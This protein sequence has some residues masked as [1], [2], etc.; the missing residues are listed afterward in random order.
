MIRKFNIFY[1][2]AGD[3]GGSGGGGAGGTGSG[4]AGTDAG[5]AGGTQGGAGADG[6]A[7]GTLL[8]GAQSQAGGAHNAG[9]AAGTEA[10]G[11]PKG[12]WGGLVQEDGTFSEA[13]WEKDPEL[14]EHGAHLSK[15]KSVKDALKSNINLQTVL[16]KK[17]DAVIIPGP[18]S[19]KDVVDKFREKLGIPESPDG[20]GLKKPDKLPDGVEWDDA[21]VKEFQK[22]AH[23][24]GITPQQAQKLLQ[25]DL[26]R[27]EKGT[28]ATQ[29]AIIATEKAE[30]KK[31]EEIL[32]KEWG[33][34]A[35]FTKNRELAVRAAI[36][37]G[38]T[39]EQLESDPIFRNASVVKAM[40]KLGSLMSEDTL[41][42]GAENG[43]YNDGHSKA[44]DIISNPQNPYYARY[45]NGDEAVRSMVQEGLRRKK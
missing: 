22:L 4:G 14:K 2:D 9:G 30:L 3:A 10:S 38:F 41:A 12:A 17:A 15:F 26:A 19:P 35:D 1:N 11:A 31:Q 25:F 27:A 23:E 28:A 40:A 16:G 32:T 45:H 24:I 36:T 18:D 13:W 20:Y 37:A 44:M 33:S 8:G 42:K 34:G 39:M 21:N 29:A 7:T 43:G 6:G 5:Q